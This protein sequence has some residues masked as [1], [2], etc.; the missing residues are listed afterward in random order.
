MKTTVLEQKHFDLG[1]LS[2]AVCSLQLL[3][4]I[5]LLLMVCGIM[6]HEMLKLFSQL[7]GLVQGHEFLKKSGK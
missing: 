7:Q 3:L 4:L 1:L 6:R 5:N 2:L